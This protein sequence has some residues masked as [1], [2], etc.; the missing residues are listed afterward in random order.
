[1]THQYQKET[2]VSCRCSLSTN[3]LFIQRYMFFAF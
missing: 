2:G 1:M 3:S